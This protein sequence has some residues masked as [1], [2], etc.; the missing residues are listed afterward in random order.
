M[1]IDVMYVVVDEVYECF[2]DG[3]FLLMFFRDF[4]RRCREVGLFFVKFVFMFVILNV[5]LFSEYF[6]GLL[7]ILVFGC[8]FFVDMIYLEYIYDILD[9]VIDSDNRLCR[10]LKGKVEDV[11]KVIKVGGGGDRWC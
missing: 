9:Y 11:M 7:V 3:D 4:L 2:L 10:R 1:F 5:V 6:G 8:L